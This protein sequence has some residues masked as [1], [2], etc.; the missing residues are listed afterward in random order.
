MARLMEDH[1]YPAMVSI[2]SQTTLD[3]YGQSHSK[4]GYRKARPRIPK[5][6]S[7]PDTNS[8]AERP[9]KQGPSNTA[10]PTSPTFVPDY[11]LQSSGSSIPSSAHADTF[12]SEKPKSKV[13]IKPFLRKFTSQEQVGIDLSRSAAEN[14]GFGV[15][16]SSQS[17]VPSRTASGSTRGFHNRTTSGTSQISTNTASSSRYV[18][19]M[20]QTPRPYTPPIAGSYKTSLESEESPY[21]HPPPSRRNITAPALHIRTGS[22]FTNS[23]QTNLPG[24]PSSLRFGAANPNDMISPTTTTQRSSLESAFRKG[25]SRSNTAQTDPAQ[26]A[27][28]VQHLRQKFQEKE[29][30]KDRKYQEA[31][32]KAMEKE[33]RRREKKQRSRAGSKANSEKSSV[34]GYGY[35]Q[36]REQ[37]PVHSGTGTG[38]PGAA[39]EGQPPTLY[40][41]PRRA[42]E[43]QEQ[44]TGKK[45]KSQWALFWIRIRT[46][47]LK[48]RRKMSGKGSS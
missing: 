9:P 17:I 13:K 40:P 23:S 10:T 19:P 42:R 27:A 28:S 8:P 46:A 29:A 44:S 47:L 26:Q 6:K 16:E 1:T 36:S 31:E 37:F 12:V 43:K 39:L 32:Q 30:A 2:A 11:L 38:S 45:A 41:S 35:D 18:H 3:D 33:Q 5:I 34:I 4:R 24:T 22:N 20:R 21:M 15:Y 7:S 14:E 25:R 48:L